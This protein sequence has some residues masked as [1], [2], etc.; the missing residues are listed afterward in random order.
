MLI[1]YLIFLKV[2]RLEKIRNV[3]NLFL[4]PNF[5]KDGGCIWNSIQ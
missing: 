5:K 4:P 2:I 1:Q 3:W